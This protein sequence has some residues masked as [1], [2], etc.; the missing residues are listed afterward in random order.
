MSEDTIQAQPLFPKSSQVFYLHSWG[1]ALYFIR[2]SF[3]GTSLVR[4]NPRRLPFWNGQ[5]R[6][7]KLSLM[8]RNRDCLR[9]LT[10]PSSPSSPHHLSE[11]AHLWRSGLNRTEEASQRASLIDTKLFTAQD[12]AVCVWTPLAS[13]LLWGIGVRVVGRHLAV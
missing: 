13:S 9:L 8:A 6:R 3:L 5:F 1:A 11:P 7:R 4:A 12:V 2:L 10:F